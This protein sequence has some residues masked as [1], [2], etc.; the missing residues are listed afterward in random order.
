MSCECY[1][2]GG[3]FIAEDPHCPKHGYE[4]VRAREIEEEENN[5][6]LAEVMAWRYRFPTYYYHPQD[7]SINPRPF[8]ESFI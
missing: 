7:D 1:K 3:P 5:K 6:L 2:I 4:A 8:R